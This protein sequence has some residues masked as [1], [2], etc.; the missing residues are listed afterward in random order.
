MLG[1]L[2][3]SFAPIKIVVDYIRYAGHQSMALHIL[4][5]ISLAGVAFGIWMIGLIYEEANRPKPLRKR[6]YVEI[7]LFLVMAAIIVFFEFFSLWS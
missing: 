5:D 1:V 3:V 2:G 6:Y 4:R 7:F